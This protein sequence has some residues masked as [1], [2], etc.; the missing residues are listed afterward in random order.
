MQGDGK[1]EFKLKL[2]QVNNEM[3]TGPSSLVK[4]ERRTFPHSLKCTFITDIM[5]WGWTMKS[6][7][8]KLT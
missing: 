3:E 6:M 5:L 4:A 1:P 8:S 7:L 2:T